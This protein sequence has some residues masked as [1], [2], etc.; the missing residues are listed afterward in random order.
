MEHAKMTKY[1]DFL[2]KLRKKFDVKKTKMCHKETFPKK[3]KEDVD[4]VTLDK[5]SLHSPPAAEVLASGEETLATLQGGLELLTH[6]VP[7]MIQEVHVEEEEDSSAGTL[8]EK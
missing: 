4:L 5:E 3:T 2:H 6:R 7:C 1:L 8:G